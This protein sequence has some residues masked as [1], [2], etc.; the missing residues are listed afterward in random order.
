MAAGAIWALL[1][2]D[3]A[4]LQGTLRAMSEST[5]CLR[6]WAGRQNGPLH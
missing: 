4:V 1:S 3:L 2:E 5:L 6:Y